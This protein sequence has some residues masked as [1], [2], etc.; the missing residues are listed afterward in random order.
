M[1][2][3]PYTVLRCEHCSKQGDLNMVVEKTTSKDRA[4]WYCDEHL[5][6]KQHEQTQ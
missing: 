5:P 1:T 3:N 4:K 2:T 6:E